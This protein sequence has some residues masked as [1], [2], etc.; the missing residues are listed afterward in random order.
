M[1]YIREISFYKIQRVRSKEPVIAALTTSN[2]VPSHHFGQPIPAMSEAT[3]RLSVAKTNLGA[4]FLS[5]ST[6][7]GHTE[8]PTLA[9]L[10]SIFLI[11]P[12]F[13]AAL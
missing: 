7:P 8:W 1:V 13:L 12:S 6:I 11:I 9:P 3:L 2:R 5:R 4:V 10:D